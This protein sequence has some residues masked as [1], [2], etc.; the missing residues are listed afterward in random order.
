MIKITIYILVFIIPI[1][2]LNAD[3]KLKQQE[4]I[5]LSLPVNETSKARLIVKG[6]LKTKV[7]RI[8]GNK[9]NKIFFTYWYGNN[10]TI[11]ILNSIG[12]YKPITSGV[13]VSNCSSDN[14]KVLVYREQIGYE[15]KYPKFLNQFNNVKLQNLKLDRKIDNISGATLS[16][17]SMDRMA[18]LA[19]L[20]N[21]QVVDENCE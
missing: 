5:N 12:K 14:M 2:M 19:L 6:E 15:I 21:S 16:V 7:Q 18:R 11:W 4:F 1:F 10:K 20:L 13:V 17:R 9:Y 3:D 8:M